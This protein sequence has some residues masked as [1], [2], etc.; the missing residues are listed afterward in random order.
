MDAVADPLNK[1][2]PLRPVQPCLPQEHRPSYRGPHVTAFPGNGQQR[3][4]LAKIA[5]LKKE[6]AKLKAERDI[7]ERPQH[8]SRGK[9]H[10]VHGG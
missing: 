9:R 2:A 1:D 4:E 8:T 3:A 5:A 6:V 7:Q 10:E